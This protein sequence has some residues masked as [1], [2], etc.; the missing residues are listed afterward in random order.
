MA[1]RA[2]ETEGTQEYEL[3]VQPLAWLRTY[4][5]TDHEQVEAIRQRIIKAVYAQEA[6]M[7][8]ERIKEGT[9]VLG[10]ERL[11]QQV[12]LRQHTPK[13]KGRRIFLI[14]SDDQVRPKAIA[15]HKKISH[16]H[17]ECYRLLKEGLPHEWP[18][19]TFIPWIPP[20]MCSPAYAVSGC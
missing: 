8:K 1:K 4:S 19:G 14:C 7:I 2:R 6:A 3:V 5:V 16:E 15:S 13:K 18:H 10:P 17:R 12:Y 11:K 9:P 20:K